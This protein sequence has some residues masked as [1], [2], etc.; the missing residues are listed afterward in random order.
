[1]LNRVTSPMRFFIVLLILSTIECAPSMAQAV[2]PAAP[3][4]DAIKNRLLQEATAADYSVPINCTLNLDANDVVRKQMALAGSESSG[5][6]INCNG[7]TL[8]VPNLHQWDWKAAP[9]IIHSLEKVNPESGGAYWDPPESISISDCTVIGGIR[10]FGMAPNGEGRKLTESSKSSSHTEGARAAA[11]RNMSLRSVNLQGNGKTIPLYISP[12]TSRVSV[13]YSTIY[14]PSGTAIYL[15]TEST[16]NLFYG[17]IVSHAKDTGKNVINIDGS[18]H[19]KFINNYF[20]GLNDG[21]IYFYRN[22]GE[23]GTI[24][25]ST[26]S[27]NH[28]IN[29]V[30]YYRKYDGDNPSIYLGSRHK[31]KDRRRTYCGD[32]KFDGVFPYGSAVSDFD[33]ATHNVIH[34]NQVI[35]GKFN[36]NRNFVRSRSWSVNHSNVIVDNESVDRTQEREA[37]CYV[38]YRDDDGG[39]VLRSREQSDLYRHPSL[40]RSRRAIL[41][42]RLARC[43]DGFVELGLTNAGTATLS[44]LW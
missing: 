26:P 29:N 38:Y 27:Y 14:S 30:F 41:D 10:I 31:D 16:E 21:G 9:I 43:L 5:V 22:C 18:S 44:V 7:A 3:C 13:L 32:D 19:N 4:D 12:G 20:S 6:V 15:D 2:N 25:H 24:R 33:H 23:G 35:K 34:Q 1:M 36:F 39:V 8:D 37:N 42:Q 40:E 11:P 28:I 17:N